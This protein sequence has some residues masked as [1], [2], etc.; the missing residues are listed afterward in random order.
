MNSTIQRNSTLQRAYLFLR[1]FEGLH[2]GAFLFSRFYFWLPL[3]GFNYYF[4]GFSWWSLL[5]LS[6]LFLRILRCSAFSLKDAAFFVDYCGKTQGEWSAA[7]QYPEHPFA[8]LLEEK[9]QEALPITFWR[10]PSALGSLILGFLGILLC[11]SF[12]LFQSS[13]ERLQERERQNLLKKLKEM[14][15]LSQQENGGLEKE[16]RQLQALL[17]AGKIEKESVLQQLEKFR[18][19]RQEERLLR[20]EEQKILESLLEHYPSLKELL[21]TQQENPFKEKLQQAGLPQELEEKIQKVSTETLK[22]A[23]KQKAQSPLDS[24]MSVLLPEKEKSLRA[25]AL[26]DPQRSLEQRTAPFAFPQKR[27][28]FSVFTPRFQELQQRLSSSQNTK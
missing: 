2:R 8:P 18:K 19:K 23:L 20:P 26:P 15:I 11:C 12:P 21:E 27:P 13:E 22:E 6:L 24:L 9:A 4:S 28:S 17:E 3:L 16:L 1:I 5:Y 7:F 25:P 14:E 10:F